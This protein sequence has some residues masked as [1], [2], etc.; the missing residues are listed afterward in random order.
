MGFRW[1]SFPFGHSQLLYSL[2]LTLG[3][4][5]NGPRFCLRMC[6]ESALPP[7]RQAAC[8]GSGQ[9]WLSL[10]PWMAWPRHWVSV[11]TGSVCAEAS[12]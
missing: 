2:C 11:R 1:S 12:E 4:G 5:R 3:D 6:R 10:S 9:V 8:P 7:L